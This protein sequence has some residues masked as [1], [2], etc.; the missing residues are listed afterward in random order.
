M[1]YFDAVLKQWILG[2]FGCLKLYC[3]H[4]NQEKAMKCK[5]V[6]PRGLHNL[7]KDLEQQ[8]AILMHVS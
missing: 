2:H 3:S 5:N 8:P 6:M 1:K 4:T 7:S